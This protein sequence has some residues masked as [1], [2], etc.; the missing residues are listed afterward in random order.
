LEFLVVTFVDGCDWEGIYVDGKLVFEN[1]SI[2]AHEALE[3]AGVKYKFVEADGDWLA[4]RGHLP[5]KLK[6]VKKAK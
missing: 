1:H 2:T 6:D 3:H 4:E 5:E